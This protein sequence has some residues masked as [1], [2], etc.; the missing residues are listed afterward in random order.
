M[1]KYKVINSINFNVRDYF[2]NQSQAIK[3]K[4]LNENFNNKKSSKINPSCYNTINNANLS[5]PFK[6]Q[7]INFK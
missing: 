5:T 2:S 1:E 3:L 7:I 6:H 4:K